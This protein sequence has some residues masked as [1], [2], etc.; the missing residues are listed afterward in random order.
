MVLAILGQGFD[1]P[2]LHHPKITIKPHK[3]GT[4]KLFDTL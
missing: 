1:P 4:L 2:H 3:I